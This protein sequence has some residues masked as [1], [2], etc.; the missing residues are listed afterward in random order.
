MQLSSLIYLQFATVLEKIEFQR[1]GFF[2]SGITHLASNAFHIVEFS[3]YGYHKLYDAKTYKL[4]PLIVKIFCIKFEN[5][6][7]KSLRYHVTTDVFVGKFGG[8]DKQTDRHD[9]RAENVIT[10][11]LPHFHA[12]SK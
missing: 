5:F 6:T 8:T 1:R 11:G 9:G 10:I 12:G 4:L 7:I 2:T 3:S